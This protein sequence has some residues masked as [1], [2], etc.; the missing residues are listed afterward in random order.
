MPPSVAKRPGPQP[1]VV[2]R[3]AHL[4][5]QLIRQISRIPG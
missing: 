3:F 2:S 1:P 4:I 5:R